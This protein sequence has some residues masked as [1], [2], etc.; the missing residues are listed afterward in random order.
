MEV[1]KKS[2]E[3][4]KII[5]LILGQNLVK[6]TTPYLEISNWILKIKINLLN[7]LIQY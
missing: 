6:Q 2:L 4:G 1:T 5:K 7:M 3:N